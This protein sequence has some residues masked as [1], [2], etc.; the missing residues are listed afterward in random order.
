MSDEQPT[1]EELRAWEADARKSVESGTTPESG[2]LINGQ[3]AF[4]VIDRERE[5]VV[6]LLEALRHAED[7]LSGL[8]AYEVASNAGALDIDRERERLS[9]IRAALV[10]Y[11]SLHP[12]QGAQG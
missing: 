7:S 8:I 12:H 9:N 10:V 11:E 3:W 4:R 6:P 2:V 1:V 5:Q